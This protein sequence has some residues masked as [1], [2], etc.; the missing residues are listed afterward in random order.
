MSYAVFGLGQ[1]TLE[2]CNASGGFWTGEQCIICPPGEFV[3]TARG[4]PSCEPFACPTGFVRD[5]SSGL[6]E[7]VSEAAVTVTPTVEVPARV[8]EVEP[9]TIVGTR[10]PPGAPAVRPTPIVAAAVKPKIPFSWLVIGAVGIGALAIVA[11]AAGGR[12]AAANPRRRRSRRGDI[13]V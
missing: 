13:W 10:P 8:H 9:V 6:C 7:P 4:S 2:E 5:P 1:A 3:T 12:R 11:V